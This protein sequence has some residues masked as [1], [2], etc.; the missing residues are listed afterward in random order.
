MIVAAALCPHPPLLLREVTGAVDAAASLRSAC[1]EAV[2][3]LTG[4]LDPATDVVHVVG[5]DGPLV[6]PASFAPSPVIKESKPDQ[7]IRARP[8]SLLVGMRLLAEAGWGGEVVPH[9]VAP[10]APPGECWALGE[11]LATAAR[12]TAV[13]A[14]GDGSARRGP[15][16]PGYVDERAASFDADVLDALAAADADRLAAVDPELAAVLLA[17]GRPAWQVL[18]G[19]LPWLGVSRGRLRYADD[20]FGVMYAVCTWIP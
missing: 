12:P 16:A 19:A 17:A 15:K 7:G 3:A 18:A 13:L 9:A 14:L 5:A 6:T 4:A 1:A 2:R 11:A 20:P 8:L 10:D